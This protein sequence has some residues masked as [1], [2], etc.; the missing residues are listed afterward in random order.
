MVYSLV[1]ST[2]Q[3][4]S[5]SSVCHGPLSFDIFDFKK[6]IACLFAN[7]FISTFSM[8]VYCFSTVVHL[9]VVVD[10]DHY[11]MLSSCGLNVNYYL[12]L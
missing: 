10:Y 11:N 1:F 3:Q 2:G 9:S 5:F 7:L 6:N 8:L 12:Y 4:N